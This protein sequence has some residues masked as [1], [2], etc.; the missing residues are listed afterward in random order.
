MK[1]ITINDIEY[2]TYATVEEAE[3][4]FNAKFG[5]L[6]QEVENKE[7][8]LVTATREIDGSDFQ[9]FVLECTQVQQFPRVLRCAVLNPEQTLLSCCCEIASAFSTM[10]TNIL[11]TPGAEN[12]QSMSVGDT[13]I[14][15]KEGATI[16]TDIYT[17]IAKPIIKK[18]LGRWLRGNIRI[19]L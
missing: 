12:I 7:Q 2:P 18:Y 6:W 16:E 10:N 17:S 4:Y 11:A 13:S 1:T 3:Q 9:G 5:S 14:T 8:L 19:I 15:F